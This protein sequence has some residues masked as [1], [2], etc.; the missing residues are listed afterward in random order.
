MW[1]RMSRTRHVIRKIA[2]RNLYR[3]RLTSI[4]CFVTIAMGAFL[5]NVIPQIKNGIQ[6]EIERPEGLKVP[7]FFL[8][9]IQ[10]EQLLPLG[11]FL[12]SQGTTLTKH[13]SPGSKA[14][15]PGQREGVLRT[16]RGKEK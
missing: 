10:P 5:I 14:D 9:D 16:V 4:S 7:G 2:F 12:E 3:H 8:I 1:G 6:D 11:R 15:Y 13:L